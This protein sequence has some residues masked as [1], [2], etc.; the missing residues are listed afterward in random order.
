MALQ[1]GYRFAV[2]MDEAFPFGVYAMGVQQAEDYDSKTGRRTPTRDKQNGDQF[3]WTVTCIDR[4]PEAREKEVKIKVTAPVMPV[5]PEEV[6][7]GSGLR[8]VSFTGLTVT[9][10]V[11]E[12]AVGRKPRMAFSWRAMEVHAAGKAPA[13][14]AAASRSGRQT[15]ASGEGKAA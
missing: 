3:V 12:V 11:P 15:S 1:G 14:Q 2:S 9:P 8:V 7:P 5:L 6:L 10:Y 4:D 13:D